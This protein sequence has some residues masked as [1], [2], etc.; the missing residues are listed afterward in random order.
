[1]RKKR[2]TLETANPA[3]STRMKVSTSRSGKLTFPRL[4]ELFR[5]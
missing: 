1:M 3:T 4:I 2:I 5:A